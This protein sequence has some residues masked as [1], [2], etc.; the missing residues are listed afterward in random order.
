M[1]TCLNNVLDLQKFPHEEGTRR[2]FPQGQQIG[3]E[4]R[5]ELTDQ[6]GQEK[7]VSI[8]GINAGT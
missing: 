6:K 7:G 5:I 2:R 4:I 3:W 1:L 8:L